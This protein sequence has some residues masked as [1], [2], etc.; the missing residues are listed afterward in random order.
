M[1]GD[2]LVE[3]YV[4]ADKVTRKEDVT[5]EM[6]DLEIRTALTAGH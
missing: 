6:Y 3:P 1:W 4:A 2:L 5:G